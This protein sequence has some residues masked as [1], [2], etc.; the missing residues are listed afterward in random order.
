[1]DQYKKAAETRLSNSASHGNH[2][3]HPEELELLPARQQ[4][5]ALW[6]IRLLRV[7]IVLNHSREAYD[8]PL[9]EAT[10]DKDALLL[11][12]PEGWQENFPLTSQDLEEEV[13][14][15]SAAGLVLSIT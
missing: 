15:Q 3:I 6:L 4:T 14:L 12:L 1:M 11:K 9:P 13:E 7:A 5:I 10:T 2:K 8:V